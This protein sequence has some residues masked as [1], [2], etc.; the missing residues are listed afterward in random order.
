MPTIIRITTRGAVALIALLVLLSGGI[1]AG[2]TQAY[3]GSVV[4]LS[5]YSYTGNVVYLF[6]TGPNLPTNG[7][8]LDNINRRADQGGATQV[9]VDGNGHW[10]YPWNTG[11]PGLDPGS[12]T[13]WVADGPA[14][15]SS[16]S[17]VDYSTI[18]VILSEPF[19]SAGTSGGSAPQPRQGS[20]NLSST[21][22]GASVVINNVYKGM[23]PLTGDDIGRAARRFAAE[24]SVFGVAW[25]CLHT[26][27]NAAGRTADNADAVPGNRL[28]RANVEG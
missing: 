19:I 3:L 10:V 9:D 22:A 2:Q 14:D 11:A 17:T 26:R 16:L 8:A 18:S 21:P 28:R 6:L 5:G 7:V 1:A 12:Y 23:T 25:Q 27:R 4:T 20:M 13:V 15:V 24:P